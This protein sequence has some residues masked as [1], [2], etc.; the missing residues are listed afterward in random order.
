MSTACV[1]TWDGI[2]EV[3]QLETGD[4]LLTLPVAVISHHLGSLGEARI[5]PS[6][7]D[8]YTSSSGTPTCYASRIRSLPDKDLA[9]VLPL[10]VVTEQYAEDNYVSSVQ[11][12]MVYASG[13]TIQESIE[14]LRW[15]VC[16]L[17]NR[18]NTF[19]NDRLGNRAKRQ[20]IVLSRH[21][22]RVSYAQAF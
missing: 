19:S 17:F 2:E 18:L 9:V 6:T 22:A 8:N 3:E 21:L 15:T 5:T 16:H 1:E 14:N 13:D 4:Y 7:T 20:K 11:E 12:A 10:N